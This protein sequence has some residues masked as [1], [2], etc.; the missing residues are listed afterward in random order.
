MEGFEPP[1]SCLQFSCSGQL[2]YIGVYTAGCKGRIILNKSKKGAAILF[3]LGVE[4]Q[5]VVFHGCGF[6][7][8]P[9]M[10][11]NDGPEGP[12]LGFNK[13]GSV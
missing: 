10:Q 8:G 11:S 13:P 4:I 3:F 5:S 9:L 1:T 12:P 2:S 6:V 7:A